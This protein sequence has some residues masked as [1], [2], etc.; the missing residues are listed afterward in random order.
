MGEKKTREE[1][2]QK[3]ARAAIGHIKINYKRMEKE[4][5]NQLYFQVKHD[6]TTGHYRET[7]WKGMF[8]RII[9]KKFV[10]E[11]SVFIIDSKGAVSR[12]VDLAIFDEMYT[13][14]IFRYGELKFI[15][16]EAV[17][18]VVECKSTK[19]TTKV[20]SE[21]T[22]SINELKTSPRSIVR[23]IREVVC[24]TEEKP[25]V[26]TQTG[27]RPLRILCCLQE[28]DSNKKGKQLFD[29]VIIANADAEKL[30]IKWNSEQE[31]LYEWYVELN[32]A[33]KSEANR[34]KKKVGQREKEEEAANYTLEDYQIHHGGTEL[35]L[36]TFHFQLNQLLMLINNPMMFPHLAYVK[37]FDDNCFQE[38]GEE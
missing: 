2:N 27:T 15:P 16:I 4:I 13:P 8:E 36:L 25:S 5:V 3:T 31:N 14:Y 34:N 6:S 26:P 28:K 29:V 37:M 21:W 24:G 12:E 17:A 9:P 1:I 7:V 38:E 33:D 22:K 10:I 19:L 30:D 20:L 11:Q 32:H 23:T 35:S 18:A